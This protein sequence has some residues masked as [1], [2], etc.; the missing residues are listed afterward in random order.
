MIDDELSRID[1]AE[2]LFELL[3]VAYDPALLR[4]NRLSVL[5]RFRLELAAADREGPECQGDEARRARCREALR[6]AHDSFRAASAQEQR[7]FRVLAPGEA[8]LVTLGRA[9]GR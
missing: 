4:V 1:G 5:R 9:S 2:E 7:L 8:P 3:D 6:R